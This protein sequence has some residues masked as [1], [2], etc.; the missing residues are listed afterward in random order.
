MSLAPN[1]RTRLSEVKTGRVGTIGMDGRAP[2]V[3]GEESEERVFHS[4]KGFTLVEM[5]MMVF[6]AL[7]EMR[8]RGWRAGC[9]WTLLKYYPSPVR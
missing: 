5:S 9:V 8:E 4:A 6:V 7:I 3:E 2:K 1:R